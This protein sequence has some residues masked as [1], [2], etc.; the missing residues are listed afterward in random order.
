MLKDAWVDSDR[1]REGDILS[2]LYEAANVK[3]KVLVRRHFHTTVC[4]GEVLT[5]MNIV[6]DT[7]NTL[8]R[9]LNITVYPDLGHYY[10]ESLYNLWKLI[11]KYKPKTH[12]R[13]VF[14]EKGR[15]IDCLNTLPEVM[16]VLNETV[17]GTS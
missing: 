12:Y 9:V 3:D 11:K 15:R 1:T 17:N 2:A 5:E 8:M 13:V 14:Q 10:S 7:S 4:H 16:K 6:D